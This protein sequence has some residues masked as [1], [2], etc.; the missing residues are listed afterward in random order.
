MAARHDSGENRRSLAVVPTVA[1][2]PVRYASVTVSLPYTDRF[3]AQAEACARL[4]ACN[5]EAT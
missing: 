2:G 4:E 3:A 1:H 5:V